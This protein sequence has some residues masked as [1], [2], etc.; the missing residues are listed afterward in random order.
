[1]GLG[2]EIVSGGT[3]NHLILVKSDSVGLTGKQA[4]HALEAAGIT[5]NK[6]MI[7]GD[8]RSPFITSGVRLGT[9][10][11]TTRGLKE[12]QMKLIANWI[13]MA[14]KS[15]DQEGELSNIRK[16]VVELCKQFPV[17]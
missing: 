10:A 11:I 9:P 2:V 6:N 17:Y 1:M 12:D 14:L 16:N 5:C 13:V 15:H 3:D 7:P 4:E 8:K